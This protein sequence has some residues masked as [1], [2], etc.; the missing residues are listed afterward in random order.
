MISI[1]GRLG[2]GW[3]GDRFDKRWVTSGN[4]I[5]IG[6]SMLLFSY[7]ASGGTWMLILFLIL[8]GFGFGGNWVMMAAMTREYFGRRNF[9][10]IHGCMMGTMALGGISGPLLAGWIFD[11]RGNYHLIWLVFACLAFIAFISLATTRPAQ[12]PVSSRS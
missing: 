5:L 11:T 7:T 12:H 9:G 1:T 3:L 8:F 4:F 6:I 10:T 2:S